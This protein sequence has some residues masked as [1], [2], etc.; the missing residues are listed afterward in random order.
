MMMMYSGVMKR[1]VSRLILFTYILRHNGIK[2]LSDHEALVLLAI[3]NPRNSIYATLPQI[4]KF[5][6]FLPPTQ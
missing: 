4:S 1:L 3:D 2:H 5:H 6:P